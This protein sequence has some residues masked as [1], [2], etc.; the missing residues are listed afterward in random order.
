MPPATC[1]V[2]PGLTQTHGRCRLG[3]PSPHLPFHRGVDSLRDVG[4]RFPLL[5]VDISSLNLLIYHES[6]EKKERREG[7]RKRG[8]EREMRPRMVRGLGSVEASFVFKKV[9]R[10]PGSIRHL[11]SERGL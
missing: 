10:N 3:G 2:L 8:E 5:G 1:V 9:V 6:G 7:K 4:P 11:E